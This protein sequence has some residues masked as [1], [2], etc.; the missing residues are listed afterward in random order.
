MDY[1][2][3]GFVCLVIGVVGGIF[4]VGYLGCHNKMIRD[5]LMKKFNAIEAECEDCK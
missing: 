5:F 2:F 4:L 3:V 1:F